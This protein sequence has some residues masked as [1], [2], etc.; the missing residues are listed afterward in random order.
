MNKR[1][2]LLRHAESIEDVDPTLHNINTG[3]IAE[4]TEEGKE[5]AHQLGK[6]L[7]AHIL[8]TEPL[9]V[10]VSPTNRVTETWDIISTYFSFTLKVVTDH[11]IR[12]LN[13]GNITLE[14]RSIIEA[15]RYKAGVL[16]FT[17]PEGD[18]TPSYVSKKEEG[19][20]EIKTEKT[21]IPPS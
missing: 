18:H 1:I 19:V 13:W 7:A 14:N 8:K 6:H 17:F 3:R 10:F 15:E 2:I 11:R 12:N 16:N 5:K 20:T 9:L 21:S 4:L